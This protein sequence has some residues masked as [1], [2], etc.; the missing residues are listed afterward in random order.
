MRRRTRPLLAVACLVAIGPAPVAAAGPGGAFAIDGVGNRSC[1]RFVAALDAG[2]REATAFASWTNGFLSASNAAMADTYDL[3][4]WQ[5][6]EVVLAKMRVFCSAN[7]EVEYVGGLTLLV[8]TLLADRQTSPSEIVSIRLGDQ[9]VF[10]YADV[11]RR[12]RAVLV[13]G[14]ADLAPLPAEAPIGF[15]TAFS[16]ALAAHQE[17]AGL[18]VTGLPDQQTLISLLD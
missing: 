2:G 10:L 13:A 15:D 4:P 8:Q 17:A 1:E 9:A 7:P 12:V 3:T 11:L 5:T 16:A 18:P 6:I 14:G